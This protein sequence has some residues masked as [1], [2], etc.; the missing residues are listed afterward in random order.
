MSIAFLVLTESCYAIATANLLVSETAP[1]ASVAPYNTFNWDF[2]YNYRTSSAVAVD[3]YWLLTAA[4]VADDFGLSS[5]IVIDGEVYTQTDYILHDTADLALVKF[6]KPFPGYYLLHDG[7][8][9]HE[10]QVGSGRFKQTIEVYEPLV[11]CGYG[12]TGAVTQ[13][14]FSNG[15]YGAWTKRWGSNEGSGQYA[16]LAGNVGG[17]AG[18]VSSYCFHTDFNTNDTPYEAGGAQHDSGSP[19]FIESGGD[20]KITG[21]TVNLSGSNPYNGNYAVHLKNHVAWITNSIPDYDTDMDGLPDHWE[22]STGETEAGADPDE[23]GFSNYEEW[24]AD[25]D[26][27]LGSSFLQMTAFTNGMDIVFTSSTNRKYQIEQNDH[28]TNTA[29]SA[30]TGWFDGAEPTTSANIPATGSNRFY[31]IR[32]RL[33]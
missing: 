30:A 13:T 12:R 14:T 15:P 6:D 4:H 32:A 25:T 26:P 29:W 3:H 24:I 22:S 19:V 33:H 17:E 5:D 8:I 7:E 20:W 16:T 11:M 18:D 27:N 31:R 10:E 2:V 23:D 21:I 1:S 28:L 9:F